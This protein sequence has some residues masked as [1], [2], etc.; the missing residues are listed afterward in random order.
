MQDPSQY[1]WSGHLQLYEYTSQI[2]PP[3]H[4]G[5]FAQEYPFHLRVTGQSQ[6]LK[7]GIHIFPP[8]QVMQLFPFQFSV[9]G[10]SQDLVKLL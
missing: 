3:V 8:V 10:H 7:A 1:I 9:G 5:S 4:S 2:L 6:L